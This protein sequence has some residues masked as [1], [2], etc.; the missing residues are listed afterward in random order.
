MTN[1][2]EVTNHYLTEADF[3][4]TYGDNQVTLPGVPADFTVKDALAMES[5]FCPA[6]PE[7]RADERLRLEQLAKYVGESAL[8]PEH[9]WL[10]PKDIN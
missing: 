9:R 2:N 1:Q 5:A 8:L 4:A 10:M 7:K 6:D 3:V